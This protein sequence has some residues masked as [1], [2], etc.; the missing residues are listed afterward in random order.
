MKRGPGG[1]MPLPGAGHEITGRRR[2]RWS[3]TPPDGCA[4]PP[5]PVA[6]E[7]LPILRVESLWCRTDS[8]GVLVQGRP[9]RIGGR[10]SAIEQGGIMTRSIGEARSRTATQRR[11]G[12]GVSIGVNGVLLFLINVAPG[13]AVLPFLTADFTAVLPWVNASMALGIVTTIGYLAVDTPRIKGIGDLLTQAVGLIAMIRLW[14]VF[15]FDFGSDPGAWP[16]VFRVFLAFGIVGAAI[17]MIVTAVVVVRGGRRSDA[18]P[19]GDASAGS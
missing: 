15:P 4:R 5:P 19:R 14:Q 3:S 13:W 1:S 18:R 6:A 16:T 9:R 10:R 17:G 11:V 8:S 12:Y 2:M 7:R